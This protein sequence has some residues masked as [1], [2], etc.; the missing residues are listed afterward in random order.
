MTIS[1]TVGAPHH[2]RIP[3]LEGLRGVLAWTVVAA[4]V[5]ICCGYFGPVVGNQNVLNDVAEAAVDVFIILSGFVITRL[6]LVEREPYKDYLV[7]RIRRIFPAYWLALAAGIATTSLLG[8]NLRHFLPHPVAASFVRICDIASGRPWPD[9]PLHIF[10]LQ[11]LAP[12]RWLAAEP[13]TFLG[14][15]WSLSLE[16]QFYI[17]APLAVWFALQRTYTAF[18]LVAVCLVFA[19]FSPAIISQFS[20]AFLPSKAALFVVGGYCCAVTRRR[21]GISGFARIVLLTGIVSALYLVASGRPF[22]ALLPAVIWIGVMACVCLRSPAFLVSSLRSSLL[23]HLGKI[24][25]STYLF[26]APVVAV[27]QYAI[28]HHIRPSSNSSLL[29]L[30]APATVALTYIASYVLWR[31]VE[32]PFQKRPARAALQ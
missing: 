5:L 14:V 9:I 8:D 11:G 25:Y 31:F 2:D 3:E 4:H 10:L 30:T 12:A 26:H 17:V 32:K 23:Q 29:L 27:I 22:E 1:N 28:W 6:I 24:S 20:N 15:A 13:Y 19:I 21:T 16:W 18:A 7:R